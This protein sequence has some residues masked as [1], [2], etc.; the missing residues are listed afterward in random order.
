VGLR[1]SQNDF[2]NTHTHTYIYIYILPVP[3]IEPWTVQPVTSRYIGDS[4]LALLYTTISRTLTEKSCRDRWMTGPGYRDPR[5]FVLWPVEVSIK[6]INKISNFY[7][8]IFKHRKSGIKIWINNCKL[9][10][11]KPIFESQNTI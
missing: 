4:I 2:G 9:P 5:K 11:E 1:A 8:R 6:T 3:V 7:F 10:E